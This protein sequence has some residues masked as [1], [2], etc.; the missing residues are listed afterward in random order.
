[1]RTAITKA[2][3]ILISKL[4]AYHILPDQALSQDVYRERHTMI[5]AKRL[6]FSTE[7]MVNDF[8]MFLFVFLSVSYVTVDTLISNNALGSTA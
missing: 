5:T 3:S 2:I 1:M 7:V 6:E 8:Y 4:I